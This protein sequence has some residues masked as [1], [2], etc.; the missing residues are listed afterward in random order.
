[1]DNAIFL[2][3]FRENMDSKLICQKLATLYNFPLSDVEYH[4]TFS[5]PSAKDKN[6]RFYYVVVGFA[7]RQA[8]TGLFNQKKKSGS[9]FLQQFVPG[10]PENENPEIFISNRLT[11][12]NLALQKQLL[13]LKKAKRIMSVIYK[14][15]VLHAK[16]SDTKII[17]VKS[18]NDLNQL[19]QLL[20]EVME[21]EDEPGAQKPHSSNR[22]VIQNQ[23]KVFHYKQN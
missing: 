14:N 20:S 12:N 6:K 17:P 4:Y 13:E 2:S 16:I 23:L 15:C 8:K 22:E 11:K 19:L 7:K 10:T 9:L 1:V 18:Q 21:Q 5:I 3:G